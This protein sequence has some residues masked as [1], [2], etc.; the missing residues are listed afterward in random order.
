MGWSGLEWVEVDGGPAIQ[1]R[2]VGFNAMDD[3]LEGVEIWDRK[4]LGQCFKLS[5]RQSVESSGRRVVESS[6]LKLRCCQVAESSSRQVVTPT[7]I[8]MGCM[9]TTSWILQRQTDNLSHI[10]VEM[11]ELS[12][13]NEHATGV[14]LASCQLMG[15]HARQLVANFWRML[16]TYHTYMAV[17]KQGAGCWANVC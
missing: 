10:A 12:F 15:T 11:S 17:E 14:P 8:V 2:V 13:G 9:V 4:I 16:R 1:G 5:S 3:A 6:G 7:I